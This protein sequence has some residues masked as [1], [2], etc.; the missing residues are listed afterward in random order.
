M[1]ICVLYI[2]IY[3]YSWT[4][5]IQSLPSRLVVNYDGGKRDG[6]AASAWTVK[7]DFGDG[8]GFVSLAEGGL[9]LPNSSTVTESELTAHE[10]GL[11]AV[12]SILA[13]GS[14]LWDLDGRVKLA[15]LQ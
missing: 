15:S 11:K 7:G 5:C 8:V 9:L 6:L 10:E 2:C 12:V 3:I 13:C 4:L 1:V 14:V